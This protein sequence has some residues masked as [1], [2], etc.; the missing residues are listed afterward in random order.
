MKKEEDQQQLK[1][2]LGLLE[3][4]EDLE[5]QDLLVHNLIW[6]HSW[7]RLNNRL[8]KRVHHLIHFPTCKLK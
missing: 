2:G 1:V 4:K 6:D 3:L 8:E 7:V 5:H